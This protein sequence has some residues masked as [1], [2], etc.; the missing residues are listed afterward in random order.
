MHPVAFAYN[1]S[2]CE[3]EAGGLWTQVQSGPQ[4]ETLTQNKANVGQEESAVGKGSGCCDNLSSMARTRE[5]TSSAHLSLH[6]HTQDV[7]CTPTSLVCTPTHMYLQV[8]KQ[9]LNQSKNKVVIIPLWY[10]YWYLCQFWLCQ[11]SV[12]WKRQSQPYFQEL[13]NTGLWRVGWE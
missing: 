2:T 8:I 9:K 11:E 4:S 1:P 7:T 5:R 6:L 10:F 3:A 12:Y 13:S